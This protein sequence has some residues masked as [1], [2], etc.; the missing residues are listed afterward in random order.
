MTYFAVQQLS[1]RVHNVCHVDN[2]G[3]VI[4]YLLNF[5]ST[6]INLTRVAYLTVRVS[7]VM[8]FDELCI[9]LFIY[10]FIYSNSKDGD[11]IHK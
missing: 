2:R 9:Y 6:V 4:C 10:L 1:P 7:C 8:L 5:G 3:T 11:N